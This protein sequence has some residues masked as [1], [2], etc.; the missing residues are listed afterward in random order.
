MSQKGHGLL[1]LLHI[2]NP[3]FESDSKSVE[4]FVIG[5]LVVELWAFCPHICQ[6]RMLTYLTHKSDFIFGKSTKFQSR[7]V[8]WFEELA[9][10]HSVNGSGISPA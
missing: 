6:I 4:I 8:F 10:Q 7:H 3:D 5:G 1:Q 2:S 9:V